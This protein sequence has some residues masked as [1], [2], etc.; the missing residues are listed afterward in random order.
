MR[1]VKALAIVSAV[2]C[3]IALFLVSVHN[4]VLT[5]YIEVLQ[6]SGRALQ[7]SNVNQHTTSGIL[8]YIAALLLLLFTGV[9]VVGLLSVILNQRQ[10][11]RS[12]QRMDVNGWSRRV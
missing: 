1:S 12:T 4:Y 9:F 11:Q 10:R 6:R 2:S 7:E 3:G 8:R 5:S